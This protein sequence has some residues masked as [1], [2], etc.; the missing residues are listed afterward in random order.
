MSAEALIHIEDLVKHFPVR[1]GAFGERRAV[2]HALD[3][4]SFD[5]LKGE[6][7]SVVGESGCGKSTTGFGILNLHRPTAGRVVYP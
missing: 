7:L 4:I 2:V 5:I 6:T 1:L 3:G